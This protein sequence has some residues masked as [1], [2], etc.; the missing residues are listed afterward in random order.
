MYEYDVGDS[1]EHEIAVEKIVLPERGAKYPQCLK[2][3]GACP[4]EDVGGVWGYAGFLEAIRDI[5]HVEHK[6]Y[7]EWI[8]GEF[9]P[10]AFDLATANQALQ[11]VKWKWGCERN[12][13][14]A[15]M[16]F[17]KPGSQPTTACSRLGCFAPSWAGTQSWCGF[18]LDLGFSAS[19]APGG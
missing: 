13:K 14:S 9:D 2:G 12:T 10:T 5:K 4:P 11:W 17:Y 3:K 8:G 16:G 15:K 7:L 18:I 6:M 1:W 19:V